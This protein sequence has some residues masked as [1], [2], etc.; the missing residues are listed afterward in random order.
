MN[1]LIVAPHI[2]DELIGCYSVLTKKQPG[3]KVFVL[4][5]N[6]LTPERQ[7]EAAIAGHALGFTPCYNEPPCELF[8]D[9]IYVPSIRDWHA[10]HKEVNRTWRGSATHFYSVDMQ[11]GIYLG[12]EDSAKKKALLDTFYPSQKQLW[13]TNAKY[14][15]FEDIQE[16]DFNVYEEHKVAED[17]TV[18]CSSRDWYERI[19][20]LE[21]RAKFRSVQKHAD[22]YSMLLELCRDKVVLKCRSTT[23]TID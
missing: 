12:A 3:Q 22:L 9:Q 8:F 15:L 16:R 11:H 20:T 18:T 2:D 4:F 13:E 19:N 1:T 6:E 14:W 10:A 7:E 17:V 23:Y 5:L 21:I